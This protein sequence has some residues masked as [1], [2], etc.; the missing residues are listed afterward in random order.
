[1]VA[2][3]VR[4]VEVQSLVEV[5]EA[6]AAAAEATAATIVVFRVRVAAAAHLTPNPHQPSLHPPQ[7]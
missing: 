2:I 3:G 4:V 5:R 6:A 7:S 1:V